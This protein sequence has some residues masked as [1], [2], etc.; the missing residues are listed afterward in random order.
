MKNGLEASINSAV[1][2]RDSLLAAHAA[3][4]PSNPESV[5]TDAAS[6]TVP[7][8]EASAQQATTSSS[9]GTVTASQTI[10]Q[11]VLAQSS[12]A[13]PASP[14]SADMSKLATALTAGAGVPGNPIVVTLSEREYFHL[15]A[16]QRSIYISC[17]SEGCLGSTV[18]PIRRNDLCVHIL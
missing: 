4:P 13:S 2:R 16:V 15:I 10:A 17:S 12:P 3:V 5:A 6:T 18:G 14:L 7:T 1:R 9:T 11:S 8:A